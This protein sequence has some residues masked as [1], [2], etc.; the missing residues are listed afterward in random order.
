M[1]DW[2]GGDLSDGE[3]V[4]DVKSAKVESAKNAFSALEDTMNIPSGST[5]MPKGLAK[6]VKKNTSIA[7]QEAKEVLADPDETFE[8]KEF[9]RTTIKTQI[10]KMQGTLEIMEGSI[11]VG[12]EPR[13]FEVYSDLNKS[14]LDACSKLMQLQKQSET[15]KMMKA[16][17]GSPSIE[18]TETKT[19]K[20]KGSDMSAFLEQL[21]NRGQG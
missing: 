14:I 8:D 4:K 15:S 11:M 16:P 9:I 10:I 7:I 19:I 17:E 13:V 1:D 6:A 12:A 3:I 21:Q 5:P 18:L 2:F 20:A